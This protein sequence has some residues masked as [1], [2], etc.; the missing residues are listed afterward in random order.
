LVKTPSEIMGPGITKG[1]ASIRKSKYSDSKTN[2]NITNTPR[3]NRMVGTTIG[4]IPN[5]A[6][7]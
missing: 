5:I 6:P 2:N 3:N 4:G 1:F 7:I